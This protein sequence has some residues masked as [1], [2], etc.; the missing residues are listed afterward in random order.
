MQVQWAFLS[1]SKDLQGSIVTDGDPVGLGGSPLDLVDLP[2]SG[3]VG[4]DG[5]LN[6]P[7]H[8]LDVPDEGLVVVTRR[9]DV[10]GGVRGPGDAVHA[11]PV[12]AQPGDGRARDPHVQD[13]HLGSVHGDGGQVGRVLPV[14]GQPQERPVL[15][16]FVDDG[17]VLQMAEVKHA[18]G[19]IRPHRGEHVPAPAGP[20]EGDIVHLLVVGDE[21]SLDVPR[22]APRRLADPSD[23]L[24]RLQTPDGAGSVDAGGADEVR[25]HFVP[26]ETGERCTKVRV[27]VL[28]RVKKGSL[29]GMENGN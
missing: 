8:L 11:G 1:N 9:A 5:V 24:T 27:L 15:G 23:H 21:L 20:A 10:A 6:G 3:R 22:D 25:L 2:L 12:V 28:F 13:D 14:P 29:D 19:P 7:R 17:R 4:Q 26:V 18:D 16:I